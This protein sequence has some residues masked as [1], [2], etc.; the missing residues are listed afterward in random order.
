MADKKEIVAKLGA[1]PIFESLSEKELGSVFEVGKEVTHD[2]GRQVV[3]QGESGAG[4]H[5]II[6]GRAEV[7]VN[8]QV[9]ATL[10]PGDFFGEMS[11]ID[12]APR[13]ATVRATEP[14]TTFS[15]TSWNFTPLLKKHP[16]IGVAMLREMSA[17]LR[18]A[19]SSHTH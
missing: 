11:L 13:S 2:E 6:D 3:T 8:D 1:V 9:Q 5:M 17:R 18:R 12:D 4:F 10:G 15:L 14:L 7:I 19:E 16:T